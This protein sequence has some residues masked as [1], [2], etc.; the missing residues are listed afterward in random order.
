MILDYVDGRNQLFEQYANV[1]PDTAAIIGESLFT[2]YQGVDTGGKIPTN[3]FWARISQ[4]TVT[5]QQSALAGNDLQRRYTADGLLFV[6][7]FSASDDIANYNKAAQLAALIKTAFRG[8]QTDGCIWFRNV[9]IQE[10]PPEN[11]WYRLNVVAEYQYDE[12]G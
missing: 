8:K 12:I 9:R 5:E 10:I 6:Q 1:L 11:A 7:I 2:V 4:Q 3:K